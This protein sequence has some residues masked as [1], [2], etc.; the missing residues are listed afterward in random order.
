[1]KSNIS[2]TIPGKKVMLVVYTA[3]AAAAAAA[4]RYATDIYKVSL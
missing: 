2:N 3:A 1:M 4:T